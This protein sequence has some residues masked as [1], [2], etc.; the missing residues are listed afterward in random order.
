MTPLEKH[1]EI[2]KTELHH[3]YQN[4]IRFGLLLKLIRHAQELI[5]AETKTTIPR[6]PEHLLSDTNDYSN[7]TNHNQRGNEMTS[8]P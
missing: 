1:M 6:H 4:D 8:I 2:M 5:E 3:M 7:D